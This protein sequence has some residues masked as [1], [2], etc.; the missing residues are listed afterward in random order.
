[1]LSGRPFLPCV[2][3]RARF[4][5][6]KKTNKNLTI[7]QRLRHTNSSPNCGGSNPKEKKTYFETDGKERF[8]SIAGHFLSEKMGQSHFSQ[9]CVRK[10]RWVRAEK[11][12][13]GKE[14]RD[15]CFFLLLLPSSLFVV[16][17]K[18]RK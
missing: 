11:E 17:R 3:K 2:F 5:K 16:S 12:T 15:F 10:R 14:L 9:K 18:K 4:P 6:K 7:R 8:D 13:G 1:V